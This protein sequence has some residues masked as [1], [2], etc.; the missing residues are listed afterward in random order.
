[1]VSSATLL[2]LWLLKP[3]TEKP[4]VDFEHLFTAKQNQGVSIQMAHQNGRQASIFL[5]LDQLYHLFSERE[6]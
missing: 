2:R 4:C 6:R 1:M 3:L 5:E